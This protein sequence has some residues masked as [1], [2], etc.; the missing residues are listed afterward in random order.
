MEGAAPPAPTAPPTAAATSS[1]GGGAAAAAPPGDAVTQENPTGYPLGERGPQLGHQ[2]SHFWNQ[3]WQE[4]EQATEFRSHHL[5]LA[6]IK[7]IM[8]L[9]EEVRV[10]SPDTHALQP[11][12]AASH[13]A[14]G[15]DD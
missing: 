4:M 7:K 6:R 8:K 15:A 5:P 9:D 11:P 1:S 3:T 14:V 2:L 10:R 12:H 13:R